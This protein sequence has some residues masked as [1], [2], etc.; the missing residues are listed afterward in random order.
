M[1]SPTS[2]QLR[3]QSALYRIVALCGLELVKDPAVDYLVKMQQ[4]GVSVPCGAEA[5]ATAVRL[6]LD[7]VYAGDD[8][9]EAAKSLLRCVVKCDM[10]NAF[11]CIKRSTMMQAVKDVVPDLSRFVFMAYSKPARMVLAKH[12]PGDERYRVFLSKTGVRQ[13][14]PLG[15]LL[16]TLTAAV[17]MKQVHS[18][19][20]AKG[21]EPPI[22]LSFAD[23]INGLISAADSA[24][25]E[26]RID[27]FVTALRKAMSG[28][29]VNL[30]KSTSVFS[31][32]PD[33]V[34]TLSCGI[35][36]D[37]NGAKILGV[38]IGDTEFVQSKA[39]KRRRASFERRIPELETMEA[40]KLLRVCV[41]Q[42]PLVLACMAHAT[43][44]PW[45]RSGMQ[46]CG[47]V[48][49]A[50]PSATSSTGGGSSSARAA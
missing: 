34:E 6:Y 37:T 3:C 38:P 24:S 36:I 50:S 42:R 44:S 43:S 46:Q 27:E 21:A 26:G 1:T 8:A 41:N 23:D 40:I 11:S 25:L 28:I 33:A 30:N 13:G 12:G 32:Q 22:A 15:P 48:F 10:T 9:E 19:Y 39:R 17:A 14:D 47:P 31:R 7:E 16:Y 45:R 35:G 29:N 20:L 5:I 18:H 2:G 4:L 49:Y